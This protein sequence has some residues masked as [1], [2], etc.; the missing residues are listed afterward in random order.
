MNLAVSYS[1][2]RKHLKESFD[3]VCADHTP[4]LVT[5]KNGENVVVISEDDFRSL[6]ETAYLCQSPKNLS[7]L[8]EALNRKEG[9][10]LEKVKD[11]LGI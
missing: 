4:L 9:R 1:E 8:L 5:R 6:Q 3:R 2:I 7:R 11:E 10:S